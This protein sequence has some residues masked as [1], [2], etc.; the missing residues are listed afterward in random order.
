MFMTKALI[1]ELSYCQ[2]SSRLF[3]T[4][5]DHD[6]PIWLDSGA[7]HTDQGRFDIIVADP[8][9]TLVTRGLVTEITHGEQVRLSPDNPFDL[10]RPWLGTD[11]LLIPGIPFAGGAIG[12]FGY[13]L[14]RRLERFPVIAE[15]GENIP[16]MAIGIYDWAIVADHREKKTMLVSHGAA[17]MTSC[18]TS[19]RTW[20][21]RPTPSAFR[22]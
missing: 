15:D 7:P 10:L 4:I 8:I 19:S 17:T 2:D 20:I 18:P 9:A 1:Q 14:A 5:R 6:W 16:D 3:E 12:Y 22:A 21:C 11:A 13:D